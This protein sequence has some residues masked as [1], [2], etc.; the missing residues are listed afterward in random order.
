ML[1]KR[2]FSMIPPIQI[3]ENVG[4]FANISN[5]FHEFGETS[6][7]GAVG[8]VTIEIVGNVGKTNMIPTK[9]NHGKCW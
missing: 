5:N 9:K 8:A 2:T 7:A 1:V 3:M 4:C 6:G